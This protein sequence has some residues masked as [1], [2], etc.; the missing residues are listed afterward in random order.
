MP[1][2]IG[3]TPDSKIPDRVKLR[4]RE[5][6]KD[7]C[8]LSGRKITTSDQVDYDHRI[9]LI[10]WTGEGHGNR[11][12]NIFPVIRDKHREKTRQ[13]VAEKAKS[14]AVRKKH[15]GIRPEP[16]MRSA[17]FPPRQKQRSATR[18]IDKWSLLGGSNGNA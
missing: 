7:I 13:D 18:P 4:V 3:K 2:W 15:L 9:A 5:R 10:N 12:S 11:E 17:G 1:E 16:T 14:A 6:E 8:Y